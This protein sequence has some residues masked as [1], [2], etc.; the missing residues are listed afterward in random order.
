MKRR[1]EEKARCANCGEVLGPKPIQRGN[2][3]YCC[4]ACAFEAQRAKD[5]GGRADSVITKGIVE[6]REK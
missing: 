1:R 3:L 2:Q 4:Q 6:P 5:C